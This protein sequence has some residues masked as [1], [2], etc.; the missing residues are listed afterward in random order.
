MSLVRDGLTVFSGLLVGIASGVLGVGGGVFLVPIMTIGFGFTQHVAQGTSLAAIIPTSV[1][2]AL[3]HDRRGT[4]DRRAA[5]W[6]GA[7]S[8]A[9]AVLGAV[10][11]VHAPREWLARAFGLVLLF[12]AYRIWRGGAQ[13][14]DPA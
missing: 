13:T 3:T 5:V 4:V 6:M 9:G 2:G 14:G 8:M 11:A 7:G 10:V 12:A 1:V